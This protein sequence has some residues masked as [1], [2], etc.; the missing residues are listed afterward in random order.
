MALHSLG[1]AR[2]EA[3]DLGALVKLGTALGVG[4]A[5]VRRGDTGE[6]FG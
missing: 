1:E 3:L 6:G 5:V 2:L 4:E